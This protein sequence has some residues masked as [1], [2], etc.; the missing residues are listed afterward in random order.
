M[1]GCGAAISEKGIFLRFCKGFASR[2]FG[3]GWRWRWRVEA[4]VAALTALL[5]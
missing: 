5:L 1:R 4:N 3:V 2:F